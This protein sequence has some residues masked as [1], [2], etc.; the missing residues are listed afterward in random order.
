MDDD[1]VMTPAQRESVLTEVVISS[2][3]TNPWRQAGVRLT[4]ARDLLSRNPLLPSREVRIR[5]K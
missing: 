1:T 4:E 5:E 2:A 3:F